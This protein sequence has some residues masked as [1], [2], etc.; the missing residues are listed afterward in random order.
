MVRCM[1]VCTGKFVLYLSVDATQT[2]RGCVVKFMHSS[3]PEQ[4][5]YMLFNI[6]NLLV[7]TMYSIWSCHPLNNTTMSFQASKSLLFK[8]FIIQLN[9][10]KQ[11]SRFLNIY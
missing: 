2:G 8:Y 3:E 4:M 9:E 1:R 11:S 6:I 7:T 5:V 10:R